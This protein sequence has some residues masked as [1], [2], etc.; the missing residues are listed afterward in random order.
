MDLFNPPKDLN[1]T[2]M[3]HKLKVDKLDNP[4]IQVVWEDTPD[5][6]TQE[7]IRRVRTYFQKKYSSTNVNVV[8]K[9]KTDDT[10]IQSIDVSVNILDE[11]YQRELIVKFLEA[12]GWDGYKEEILKLDE[13]IEN[14]IAAEKADATPFKKWFIKK[15]EF[16]NFLSFGDGQILDFDKIKGIAT[17]ES[18]PPNF[19]G[20][21]V[22]TVDLLLFLF[23]NQTTKTS[24]AEEIFNR[25]RDQ[26]KV[27]VRG[28]IQID[29]ED[30]IIVREVIRKKKR[31]GD[32]YN[33]STTL[34]FFK[35]LADGSLQNFTGEQRRE[36]EEFIKTSIGS[37]NDFLMTILTT[38][39][40]LE[41][42]IDAKPTAR[43][44]VLSRFLGLDS[45]KMKED[46]AKEMTSNF[47]KRMISNIHDVETLKSNIE[48]HQ[49]KIVEENNVIKEHKEKLKDVNERIQKGQEYRDGLLK[50]KHTGLDEE[51]LRVNPETLTRDI[52]E[53]DS[54]ITLTELDLK[55][56]DVVEPSKY[57]HEDE[58]D[59]VKELLSE[60]KVK[61]GTMQSK[62]DDIT[63]ELEGFDGGLQCQYCGIV[64]AQ[65]EYTEK[66]KEELTVLINGV[67]I[68]T[69]T[70]KEYIIKEQSFVDLK[71][72]FDQYERNK[73]IKEKYEI[74]LESLKLKKAQIVDKLTRFKKD[75]EKLE[76]NKKIDETILR[77]DMRLEDL[78]R[79]KDGVN[80]TITN[81]ESN[82]KKYE[83]KI[84]EFKGLIEKIK[85]EEEK[86][87]IYKVLSEIFGKKGIAKMIMRSMTPVINSELQR[88]LMD[89]AEFKL[90]VR[91]S[92]KD[93]VEFWMIDN[94][95]QIEKLMSSGSGFERTM[96]S[97]ALRAVLSK[98][99]SLPKP[100]VVVFDEVFGKISNDN[101]EMVAE[102]FHKIKE[103]FEKILI[104][105]HNP[106]VSQWADGIVKIE[107]TN[108]VS[109]VVQ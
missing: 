83:E 96:A 20:K 82:I 14:T 91:I 40:N 50:Q 104:I 64:L 22:L 33:V 42:L 72:E 108:N 24:K 105:T 93:E 4:R 80:Y 98:V 70:V 73:L 43:G 29:G 106:M 55:G 25:F 10:D 48:E 7:R 62:K 31:T 71:K 97:L 109:K 30:Y 23:F 84:E 12:N 46:V 44:Q 67:A 81:T 56:I 94:N 45:L 19:G 76:E 15:I 90:E 60:E 88:L 77:A 11:N 74:Q 87:K 39:T 78:Q 54:K 52:A 49:Q 79:E 102:F 92:D 51:L 59:K 28:E 101:L 65:S 99:C 27:N 86:L 66:K 100:N 13:V 89:S 16:S 9:V 61:L 5:N 53:Y 6:F 21:T 8:T 69:D 17:V 57:Y 68:T 38:S 103:Y 85:E 2:H 32:E 3:T 34:D 18:N 36:T 63:E 26:D 107:K 1:Y 47:T 41:E 95:T 75:Q 35:K 37:M 58:H